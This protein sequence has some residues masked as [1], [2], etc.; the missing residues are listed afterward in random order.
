MAPSESYDPRTWRDGVDYSRVA[1]VY[2]PVG[3]DRAGRWALALSAAILLGGAALA[4]S[5]RS[6]RPADVALPQG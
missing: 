5:A 6:E 3:S 4:Y 1:R 2:P